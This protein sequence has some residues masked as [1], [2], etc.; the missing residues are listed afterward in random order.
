MKRVAILGSTGSV[1][2]SALDVISHL[3]GLQVVALSAFSNWKLLAQ[4]VESFRPPF[5][6][7]VKEEAASRLERL[8]PSGTRLFS[9]KDALTRIIREV[10][11][12]VLL[13]AVVG[14]AG[15]RPALEALR[16]G[17]TL[18]LANKESLVMA[19]ELLIE[20]SRRTGSPI[21]PVDSEH[22]AIFQALKAGA[23]DAVSRLILTASGGPFINHPPERLERVTPSEALRHP[24]W[25]MGSKVTVDS[26]TLMNKAFEVIEA[27]YLFEVPPD[28]I[29]VVIHPES[30]VHSMVEFRDGSVI[31]Q[32]SYPD[33]RIPIQYAL[34]YPER[35][36]ASVKRLDLVSL[37]ALTFREVKSSALEAL[38][39]GYEAIRRKGTFGAALNAAD[40]VAVSLFLE[41]KIRFPQM[42]RIVSDVL[43]RLQPVEKVGL[44]EIFKTDA[45]ARNEA[46]RLA[47]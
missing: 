24:S 37:G 28:K 10:E 38:R 36:P 2:T 25:K 20:Q 15:L 29:E 13:L 3:Q 27:H 16:R 44:E 22:S 32:M 1:G 19:G 30:V 5:V 45:W 34:T 18:A 9:G 47:E 12:D 6:A 17:V 39:L 31:A 23:A 26:A 4:Q 41:G 33:M 7:M 11:M 14:S 21:L 8:L 42:V 35:L 43:E 46:R 40:E